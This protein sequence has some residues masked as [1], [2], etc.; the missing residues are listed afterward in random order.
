MC[1]CVYIYIYIY[2]ALFLSRDGGG[3]VVDVAVAAVAA[4][5]RYSLHR[6]EV[7]VTRGGQQK[8]QKKKQKQKTTSPQLATDLPRRQAQD[9]LRAAG[10]LAHQV[11]QMCK[12][13]GSDVLG[14][15][16]VHR[17]VGPVVE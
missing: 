3:V 9:L 17:G 12:F 15:D 16:E 6:G 1:V 13:R 5:L 10:S 2:I 4:E 8:T 14:G 7:F 11:D